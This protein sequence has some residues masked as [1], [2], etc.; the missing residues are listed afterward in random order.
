MNI[1]SFSTCFIVEDTYLQ[2]NEEMDQIKEPQENKIVK[3]REKGTN[4][5]NGKSQ[6]L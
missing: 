5:K 3:S 1:I 6:G 2:K 4:T